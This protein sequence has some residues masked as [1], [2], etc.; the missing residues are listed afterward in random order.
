MIE[1]ISI[2]PKIKATVVYNCQFSQAAKGKT[3]EKSSSH[4]QPTIIIILKI[5]S[6]PPINTFCDSF[7][8]HPYRI[9]AKNV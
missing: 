6:T 8:L 4:R 5:K 7:N 2:A 9:R 3:I 1:F